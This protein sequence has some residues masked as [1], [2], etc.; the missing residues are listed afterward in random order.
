LEKRT[1]LRPLPCT[2][3]LTC[4]TLSWGNTEAWSEA[5]L[6]TALCGVM[7][8][9]RVCKRHGGT[10]RSSQKPRSLMA[11][12]GDSVRFVMRE[13]HV[14]LHIK[15]MNG[16]DDGAHRT[17]SSS[18]KSIGRIHQTS[19]WHD[20]LSLDNNNFAT[21]C[22]QAAIG[23]SRHVFASKRKARQHLVRSR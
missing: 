16:D 12:K 21:G 10:S 3:N 15:A 14:S 8:S 4:D 19:E 23:T 22:S 13:V 2:S 17:R 20:N 7:P 9:A 18:G 5:H 1:S 11:L 6:S